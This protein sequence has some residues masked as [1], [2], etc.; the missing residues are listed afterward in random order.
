MGVACR[1]S[2]VRAESPTDP[3]SA[4]TGELG[5]AQR[6]VGGAFEHEVVSGESLTAIGARFGV[7][8]APL[9]RANGLPADARLAVGQRLRVENPHL[10]PPIT[11]PEE[12]SAILLNVPQRMLFRFREGELVTAYPIAAGRP[13]WRTPLGT[14]EIDERKTDK[15]WIVPLSIQEEMRREGKRVLT[16]VP[17]GPNNPL[18]RHWL[19]LSRIDCGIHAT[20]APTSIYGLRTHG[21]IR[22]NPD[23]AAALYDDVPLGTPVRI[24]YAPVLLGAL[25]DGRVCLEA[26][27]DAYAAAPPG[28]AELARL[29]AEGGLEARIDGERAQAVLRE[30]EGIAR[31]VTRGAEKESCT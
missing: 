29:A 11:A 17:P 14:F 16:I 4:V 13:T 15:P 26:H 19:G 5:L 31:D 21:C 10:V 24:V 7:D 30:R 1:S 23:D 25:A 12:A 6:V 18:G 28:E 22:L 2:A 8:V 20:N 9:A 3:A 27:R